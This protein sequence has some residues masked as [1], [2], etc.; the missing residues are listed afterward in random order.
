LIKALQTFSREDDDYTSEEAQEL[1]LKA[2]RVAL[3]SP[4]RFDFQDLRELPSVQALSDSH[5]VYS[6]LLDIF[7]EQDL[8]DFNDFN[9]EHEGFLEKE[10]LD[11]DR[12]QRKM[13]L[14]TYASLAATS[15]NREIPYANVARALAIPAEDVEMWTIDVIRA[16]LV[17]GRL[18]QQRQTF[19]V[20]RATYRVFGE[21]QWRELGTRV[22]QFKS[23]AAKL[24]AV[25]RKQ[26]AEAAATME[27][28]HDLSVQQAERGQIDDRSRVGQQQK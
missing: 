5:P 12:L 24:L 18:S 3:T 6:Q 17:E 20:H 10:K 15:P 13:R 27:R 4:S 8:E 22:D 2:V 25:I 16:G 23:V 14:L 28:P 26:Q 11:H 9:E 19:L 21:K 1:S 7:A